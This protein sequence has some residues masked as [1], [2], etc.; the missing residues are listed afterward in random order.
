M[1]KSSQEIAIIGGGPMGLAVAYE[2]TLLGH[3][4]LLLEADNRLGGMAA[5]FDFAGLRLE[6]YYHF[7]CLSD[8]SFLEL[9]NELGLKQELHWRFTRMGFFYDGLLY[10]W[11]SVKSIIDFNR[12]SILTRF[13]Y[14][15]HA[16]RCLTIRDWRHL[17]QLSATAWL[18]SWLGE[19]GFQVLWQK[20]FAYKFFHFSDQVS[21]A[22]IWSRIRRL[23]LSRRRMRETLGFLTGGSEMLINAMASAITTNGGEIKLS[24]P[25]QALTPLQ[26]GGVLVRTSN[27]EYSFDQVIST[28]PLPL[29]EPVLREGG[30][31]SDI[32]DQYGNLPSVACACVVFQ[33]RKAVTR[34]FWTNV[35]DERF[36]IPGVIEMSNLR[37]F[38]AHVVYVPFYIPADHP[39]YQRDD[40][41]FIEDAWSC[42]RAIN[43]DLCDDDLLESHCSR[44]L[45]AQP[46]CGVNF[47]QSLPPLNPFPGVFLCDTSAYYPE[48]RGIS[49]SIDF[50][51]QLARQIVRSS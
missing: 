15:F 43:Q 35:N 40:D 27:Q 8:S 14:L 2:L 19:K 51:R 34:N 21:A 39:N 1:S 9:L 48:D 33:I 24:T 17:D 42:L 3:K 16:A 47:Q 38:K 30:V 41:A 49:E 31:S 20:L 10:N 45:Y 46:V 18:K 4:P 32:A 12:L 50:G 44:Y 37:P 23:G 29:L 5:C 28:I 7:H 6:R 26:N 22:W 11:G 13:R 36:S 25:V